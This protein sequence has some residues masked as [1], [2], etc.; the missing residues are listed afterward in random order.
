[1][2]IFFLLTGVAFWCMLIVIVILGYIRYKLAVTGSI[3]VFY[4]LSVQPPNNSEFG[5]LK[6]ETLGH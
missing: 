3:E 2:Y 4:V 6:V 1:M 5:V